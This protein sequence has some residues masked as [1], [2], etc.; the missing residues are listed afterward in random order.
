MSVFT[1][2]TWAPLTKR[3]LTT[4]NGIEQTIGIAAWHIIDLRLD[5]LPVVRMCSAVGVTCRLEVS[6]R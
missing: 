1:G 2:R 3:V 4:V 6:G 5:K